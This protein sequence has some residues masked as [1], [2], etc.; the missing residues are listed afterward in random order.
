MR[1]DG[2]E[3]KGKVLTIEMEVVCVEF[4]CH[5]EV[6]IECLVILDWGDCFLEMVVNVDEESMTINHRDIPKGME[7]TNGRDSTFLGVVKRLEYELS[8]MTFNVCDHLVGCLLAS[9]ATEVYEK[10]GGRW[11]SSVVYRYGNVI[12]TIGSWEVLCS[13]QCSLLR[14]IR[15][16]L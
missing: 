2:R 11:G 1:K 14:V 12:G 16:P 10:L 3:W 15:S 9:W 4:G 5:F 13:L 7:K 8:D 6:E